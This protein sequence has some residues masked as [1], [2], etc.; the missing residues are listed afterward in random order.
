MASVFTWGNTSVS[1]TPSWGL[2]AAWAYSYPRPIWRGPEGRPPAGAQHRCGSLIRP[3]RASSSNITRIAR[4]SP[5]CCWASSWTSAGNFFKLRLGGLVRL[6]VLGPRLDFAPTLLMQ[7]AIDDRVMDRVA[8]L[9][10]IGL[11]QWSGDDD[12]A[13]LRLL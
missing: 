9:V 7:S 1:S 5:A 3:K 10:F 11:L 8:E 12:L 2:T 6:R 13:P 4:P